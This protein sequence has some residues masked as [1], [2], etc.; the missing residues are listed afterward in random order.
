MLNYEN[1]AKRNVFRAFLFAL[2]AIAFALLCVLILLC[3]F[4]AVLPVFYFD[5]LWK[6]KIS[7]SKIIRVSV[8]TLLQALASMAV[9]LAVGLPM[10]FFCGKRKFFGKKVL[11]SLSAVPLCVPGLIIALGYITFFGNA[12]FFNRFFMALFVL[13]KPPLTFLYSVSGLVIAQGFYNF[14]LITG[15]VASAWERLPGVYSDSA[16]LLGAGERRVF[17]TVTFFELLPSIVSSCIPVFIYCFF[18]FMLVLLFGGTG[19]STLEVEIY[20]AAKNTLD[21][22]A[23]GI[24]SLIETVIA[25]LVVAFYVFLENRAGKVKG[26][27]A[28]ETVVQKGISGIK[29]R[30]A[31]VFL[32]LFVLVFFLAPL[33]SI[34]FNAFSSAHKTDTSLFYNFRKIFLSG[35][36][37]KAFFT[38][39]KTGLLTS[40]FCV[41]AGFFYSVLL[42]K[43]KSVGLK[44]ISMLP[45]AVSSVVT[46]FGLSLLFKRG[47][48]FLL[49]LAQ[50]ALFWPMAFRQIFPYISKIP[51]N[52]VSAAR[53]LSRSPLD[54]VFRIYFPVCRRGILSAVAFCFALSAGDTSLPLVLSLRN[55]DTLS[56]YIYRLAGSYRFNEACAAGVILAFLCAA[57]FSFSRRSK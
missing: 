53:L 10:A 47:N 39:V 14:P 18:S 48:F 56:L 6:T 37:Y 34:I 54:I 22:R 46:G 51:E 38:T 24:L 43:S 12:G 21:F 25:C 19:C 1:S 27:N 28:E 45:M 40:V 33:F 3:L 15:T 50:S 23:A 5:S 35:T 20:Q 44:V 32:M 55:F 31:F 57:V 8:F 41:F 36:F 2:S 42:R 17:C 30:S 4:R 11:L 52:A 7:I 9:A 49:V 29:E 13:E 16:R 26:L